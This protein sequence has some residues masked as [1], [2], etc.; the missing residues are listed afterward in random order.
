MKD[1]IRYIPSGEQEKSNQILTIQETHFFKLKQK[2]KQP[3]NIEQEIKEYK[4][5]MLKYDH[6]R[7]KKHKNRN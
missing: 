2:V 4:K 3:L 6:E 7:F 1:K 5:T